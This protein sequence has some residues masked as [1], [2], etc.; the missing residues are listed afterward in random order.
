MIAEKVAVVVE[1][2]VEVMEVMAVRIFVVWF[3]ALPCQS[4]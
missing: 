1:V 3:V 2:A 4:V